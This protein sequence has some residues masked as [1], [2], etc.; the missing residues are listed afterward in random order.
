M[1]GEEQSDLACWAGNKQAS[2]SRVAPRHIDLPRTVFTRVATNKMRAVWH[3]KQCAH[4]FQSAGVITLTLTLTLTECWSYYNFGARRM[5]TSAR[6]AKSCVGLRQFIF[7]QNL[8]YCWNLLHDFCLRIFLEKTIRKMQLPEYDNFREPDG[9]RG[10][11]GE[12]ARDQGTCGG[13]S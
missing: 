12:R 1:E 7:G 2:R 11:E 8:D 9:S 4:I 13:P 6:V 3:V 10:C 5:Y